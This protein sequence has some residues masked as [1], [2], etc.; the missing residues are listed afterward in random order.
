MSRQPRGRQCLCSV[1]SRMFGGETGYDLHRTGEFASPGKSNTRRCMTE[2]E[3][4]DAGLCYSASRDEWQTPSRF[5][6]VGEPVLALCGENP[7]SDTAGGADAPER[8][9]RAI[10]GRTTQTEVTDHER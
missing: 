5:A 3:M 8:E 1:C 6:G 4:A 10:A 7:I 9:P 2:A